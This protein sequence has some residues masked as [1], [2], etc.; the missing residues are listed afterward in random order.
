MPEL[1]RFIF[2]YLYAAACSVY[3]FTLGILSARNRGLLSTIAEHFGYRRTVSA[4]PV[5]R[6][7]DLNDSDESVR[8]LELASADGN[9]STL[10]LVVLATLVRR[11]KPRTILEIGTFDGRTTL[12][13]AA[14]CSQETRIYTLDLPREQVSS[15]ALPLA[16]G[17]DAYVNKERSGSRFLGTEY[18]DRIVQLLGD[19]ASFDFSGLGKMDFI[20]I[21]GSH[22]YE[23]VLRDSRTA[24]NLLS[25]QGG[26]IVWHDYTQWEGVNKA[27]NELFQ[28]GGEFKDLRQIEQTTMAYLPVKVNV[29]QANLTREAVPARTS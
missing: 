2:T 3:L 23:Y 21:D 20:F 8:L 12:N 16:R 1:A 9:V 18:S 4:L 15:T 26:V 11:L 19:S 7:A 28:A 24:I 17:E 6:L 5:A 22:A 27:L 14:N 10:E 13:L 29:S 25:V